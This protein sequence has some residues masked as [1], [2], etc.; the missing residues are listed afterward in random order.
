MWRTSSVIVVSLLVGGLLSA[1][2]RG[3]DFGVPQPPSGVTAT[4]TKDGIRVTWSPAPVAAPAVTSYVV[5]AGP[6][7]C[8]VTVPADRLSAVMPFIAGP[9]TVVPQVQAVND[10]GFSA[11]ASAP[12]VAVPSKATPGY[13]NIQFLE[14]SDFHGAIEKSSSSI[15]AAT[16]V[17]AFNAD[18]ATVRSTFLVSAGDSIGGAPVISS[19]FEELPT[20]AALNYMHLDV[21]GFGNHEHDR[22]LTHVRKVIAASD[23]PWVASNYSSLV[24][25]QTPD[26][27]AAPFVVLERGRVNVGFVAMNTEDVAQLVSDGNLSFGRNL[28]KEIEVSATTQGVRR[29]VRQARQEGAQLVV[30]L[31]HDGWAEDVAGQATGRLLDIAHQLT[32]VDVVYGGHSHQQYASMISGRPVVE[33]PNSGQMYSRTIVCLDTR[34]NKPIGSS[35]D[36]V[37]KAMLA[38]TPED[39]ATAAMV[40]S[41][42]AQLGPL[43]DGRIGQVSG[44]FPRGGTPPVER[45]SETPMGD[46]AA[47]AIRQKYG[48]QFAII[49]GGGIRDTLPAKGYSPLDPSLVRPALGSSGPYDVTLGDAMS[50]FPFGNTAAETTMTGAQLWMALENG[51][52]GWPTDGRFPQVSGFRFT[53]DPTKPVGSRILS[54]TLPDGTP[55]ARDATVYTVT[56]V[57]YMVYGGD[58]YDNVFNPSTAVMRE[59]YVNAIVE[60]LQADQAAGIVTQVPVLDG[61]ITRA[62]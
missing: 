20:V 8:P 5:H 56:T 34:T 2:A 54:V 57:D 35:V 12:P 15:G 59:P 28:A 27:G 23:F 61:R 17:T 52:S 1:P 26:N 6:D 25:L 60:A 18:R 13:R 48:T 31:L 11:N 44:V 7:S 43:L 53:F 58:G 50:V 3:D 4:V 38:S 9:T 14:F 10:Y 30:A 32:G 46:F 16:L 47:D 40:A 55:I 42:K 22:P 21:S 39:P 19:Q 41:Y 33:V 37:T 24:P 51:V 36:F 49:N 29:A 45:S 62:H